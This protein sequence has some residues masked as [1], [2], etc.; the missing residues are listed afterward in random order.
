MLFGSDGWYDIHLAMKN[1]CTV[2]Y[3]HYTEKIQFISVVQFIG[4]SI[5]LVSSNNI[6]LHWAY[7][8]HQK[9]KKIPEL[10]YLLLIRF[11]LAQPKITRHANLKLCEIPVLIKIFLI[12]NIKLNRDKIVNSKFLVDDT[13]CLLKS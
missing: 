4:T 2:H 5:H 9:I 10:F 11:L 13:Y 1:G 12:N 8:Y 7:N 3:R 6:I